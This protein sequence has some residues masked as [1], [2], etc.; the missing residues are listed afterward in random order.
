V[1]FTGSK[2]PASLPPPRER[3]RD[4]YDGKREVQERDSHYEA[5]A[6]SF[7]TG[8]SVTAARS[9]RNDKDGRHSEREISRQYERSSVQG[10]ARGREWP[11]DAG[12][13]PSRG[14]NL[15]QERVQEE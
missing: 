13:K 2:S 5:S 8:I 6:P 7:P 15:E 10:Y 3:D 14:R 12:V 4:L 11:M 1:G 9:E